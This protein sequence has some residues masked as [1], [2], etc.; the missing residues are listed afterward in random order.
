[1]KKAFIFFGGVFLGILVFALL[2]NAQTKLSKD[3]FIGSWYDEN[4][5]RCC[6]EIYDHHDY[7]Y[8]NVNWGNNAVSTRC[9]TMKCFFDSK[10]G[11][12]IY[13]DG[14]SFTLG[15][16]DIKDP[17]PSYEIHYN[18]DS[19]KIK[20][21]G[22]VL[23]I[24]DSYREL[25]G[26]RFVKDDGNTVGFKTILKKLTS[27]FVGWFNDV[28][29]NEFSE[30]NI[31]GT[32]KSSDNKFLLEFYKANAY[33]YNYFIEIR[34]SSSK[35]L[36]SIW[37]AHCNINKDTG[38]IKYDRFGEHTIFGTDQK[39]KQVYSIE[40]LGDNRKLYFKRNTFVWKNGSG[41][42]IQFQKHTS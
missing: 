36:S 41:E 37:Q 6:L 29:S 2:F 24:N 17:E 25:I 8:V 35:K 34:E 3:D 40:D 39:G 22:D 15:N 28:F 14:N 23:T 38:E 30:D 7:L 27:R 11:E 9:W 12:L 33:D 18:D 13:E 32:W 19:G 16:I 31:I 5:Q 21:R 10:S 1:M 42:E 26:C 20:I 4:S